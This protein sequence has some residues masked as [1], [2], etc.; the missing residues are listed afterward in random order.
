VE[1]VMD[2]FRLRVYKPR[3][4]IRWLTA[5]IPAWKLTNSGLLTKWTGWLWLYIRLPIPPNCD[6][7]SG[8]RLRPVT[9]GWPRK[10]PEIAPRS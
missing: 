4:T 9:R 7:V 8:R 2:V 5:H 6:S 10:F 1:V 3:I